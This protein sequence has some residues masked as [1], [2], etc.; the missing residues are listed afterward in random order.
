MPFYILL[1]LFIF[2]PVVEIS[3]L[4]K[5]GKAIGGLYTILF[6]IFT[7]VLG[8]YLVKAQGVATLNKLQQETN[9]GRVPAMQLAEGVALLFA[10]AV[11]LTPGFITDAVGFSLLIPQIRQGLISWIM[12]K[13]II[14]AQTTT[15]GFNH[16]Q[17]RSNDGDVIEGEYREP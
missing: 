1:F 17:K 9:A 12:K 11:L 16:P 8:A 2:V 4:I 15:T 5:I 3:F 14:K 10:G 7:A 13:G 6:V